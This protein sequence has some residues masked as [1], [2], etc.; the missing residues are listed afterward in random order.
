MFHAQACALGK[1]EKKNRATK[2]RLLNE[3][4]ARKRR[5]EKSNVNKKQ[6][7]KNIFMN[8]KCRWMIHR[9]K[10]SVRMVESWRMLQRVAG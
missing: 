2:K 9:A 1:V 4:R 8:G 10:K 7:K 6:K 5:R 3:R